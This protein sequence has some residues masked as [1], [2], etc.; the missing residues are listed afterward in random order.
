LYI[1]KDFFLDD[2]ARIAEVLRGHGFA[3]VVS[4]LEGAPP[5]ATHLPIMFEAGRGA[6]GTLVAH[7]ARANPHWRDFATLTATGGEALV[8]FS[9]PHAYV[10]PSW[11]AGGPAVPTWNYVAVHAYGVPRLV[12]DPARVRTVLCEL[13]AANESSRAAPWSLE[14]QDETY[15]ARMMRAIVVFEIPIARLEAKAKLNQNK[16]EEDRR[17]VIAAL[18][19]GG[20]S[21]AAALATW[22]DALASGG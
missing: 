11:Y 22:M 9:G 1:P 19:E 15:L 16:S 20:D 2:P 14:A 12:E 7:M 4:A 10:S 5:R 6:K 18:R 17:G 3:V 21:T 8:V 13:V